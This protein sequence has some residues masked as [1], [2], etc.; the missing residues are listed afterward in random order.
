M[1]VENAVL[2]P[3]KDLDKTETDWMFSRLINDN[4]TEIKVMRKYAGVRGVVVAIGP[5]AF[6]T[7]GIK[8]VIV[9]SGIKCIHAKAFMGSELAE[10][11]L[12]EPTVLSTI[13]ESAFAFCNIASIKFPI[14]VAEIKQHAFEECTNL[15]EVS[16]EMPGSKCKIIDKYAFAGTRIRE[17]VFPRSIRTIGEGAF[18]AI[19]WLTRVE[20]EDD[21]KLRHITDGAFSNTV[22][23]IA[24]IGQD[25]LIEML[26]D[27]GCVDA[28]V[29]DTKQFAA[30]CEDQ[31]NNHSE[32]F[33]DLNP[34]DRRTML[35]E[36]WKRLPLTAKYESIKSE[37]IADME[38]DRKARDLV[39]EC[40]T[41][42][43]SGYTCTSVKKMI[44]AELSKNPGATIKELKMLIKRQ[45]KRR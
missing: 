42:T 32:R 36:L 9:D 27:A 12:L 33:T 10:I 5:G 39:D 45:T 41:D 6:L 30:F 4:I 22:K 38:L 24:I 37:V 13:G 20:F 19:D 21:S 15:T 34:S 23:E 44:K 25:H 31:I 1:E 28:V 14:T 2:V 35:V 18:R 43:R 3:T 17:I 11:V 7:T 26:R 16:W 40:Y 29:V 8:K